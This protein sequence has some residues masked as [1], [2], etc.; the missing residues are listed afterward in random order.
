MKLRQTKNN[1]NLKKKMQRNN[2]R[3]TNKSKSNNRKSSKKRK[4]T[5]KNKSLKGGSGV[6]SYNMVSEGQGTNNRNQSMK[7]NRSRNRNQS[8]KKNNVNQRLNRLTY[9][10]ESYFKKQGMEIPVRYACQVA[11]DHYKVGLISFLDRLAQKLDKR[12]MDH[13]GTISFL[14]MGCLNGL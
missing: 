9:L 7:R 14:G 13:K 10:M 12:R 5:N 8:M 11:S 6:A 1:Y 2:K 3:K 4:H